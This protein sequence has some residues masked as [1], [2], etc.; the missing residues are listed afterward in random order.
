MPSLPLPPS[1]ISPPPPC[2]FPAPLA[3]GD[4]KCSLG[5]SFS[6]SYLYLCDLSKNITA[7]TSILCSCPGPLLR[8]DQK[9]MHVT[10]HLP[11][12]P[13]KHQFL[14][15]QPSQDVTGLD[16]VL[17]MR[18]DGSHQGCLASQAAGGYELCYVS[19]WCPKGC[20][21][22]GLGW[23]GYKEEMW[24][25]D[26]PQWRASIKWPPSDQPVEVSAAPTV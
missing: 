17:S 6:W 25:V 22:H 1:S 23:R 4:I 26:M 14:L 19:L 15:G 10:F 20:S 2:A 12:S 7:L 9:D 16:S 3:W 11:R 21:W 13:S 8:S 24:H 5:S 18:L